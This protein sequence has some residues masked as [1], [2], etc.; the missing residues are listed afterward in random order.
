[1][2]LPNGGHWPWIA[3][4]ADPKS[5]MVVGS[6]GCGACAVSGHAARDGEGRRSGIIPQRQRLRENMPRP[7]ETCLCGLQFRRTRCLK[8]RLQSHVCAS[9]TSLVAVCDVIRDAGSVDRLTAFACHL[10]L[11]GR[12]NLRPSDSRLQSK[13]NVRHW[14]AAIDNHMSS[15]TVTGGTN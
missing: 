2:P 5:P 13:A 4:V 14:A 11:D 6:P 7:S 8:R 1:M 3:G 12:A 9:S 15:V 10:T